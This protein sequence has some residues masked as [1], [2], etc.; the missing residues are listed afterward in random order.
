MFLRIVTA[1]LLAPIVVL[2]VLW[3][4][5]GFGWGIIVL[6]AALAGFEFL[7]LFPIKE[8]RLSLYGGVLLIALLPFL[9][10]Y[11]W[12]PLVAGL[13]AAPVA[14]LGLYLC[15]P[16][17][18]PKAALETSAVGMGALYVG[19]LCASC[20]LLVKLPH[21]GASGLLMLC[22]V[23]WLGD[24]GAYFGGKL[25]G[26]HKLYERVSPKKTLEGSFFGLAASVG[27]AFLVD[28]LVDSPFG[29]AWQLVLI[30]LAGGAA[31]Q[32]G[33]LGESVLKRSV[34]IKDSGK[35]LP[36]HGGMLDRID[37]LL[38]SG[39]VVLAAYLGKMK[40]LW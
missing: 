25:L 16:G 2:G 9:A 1:L 35:L 8:S 7:S 34:G 30:G 13:F 5:G 36:G 32:I 38:F 40:G 12:R 11:G 23:V 15:Q 28:W 26:R 33:D 37:G 21:W 14:A 18:L 4:P 22:S 39:P 6:T 29:Q 31:E 3:S 20:V 24:S 19:L 27:G 17:R 10:G